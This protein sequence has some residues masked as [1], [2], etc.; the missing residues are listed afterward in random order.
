M[1]TPRILVFLAD[2]YEDLEVHYPRLRLLEAGFS[3]TL[4]GPAQG[5]VYRGKHGY[6][7]R[8]DA[9]LAGV[10]AE[11]FDGLVVPGGWMPDKLRRDPAVLAITHAIHAAGKLVASICH[12][13]WIDISARIVEGYRYT[14]TPGIKDDLQNA[15][16]LWSDAPMVRDRNRV[17]SR[18][19]DDLPAFLT[20]ILGWF[21][22]LKRR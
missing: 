15:G 4:A 20:G 2:D 6:P 21:E 9:A 18:R 10:D 12:G 1:S 16:A 22:E 5:T 7:A 13:P 14:S 11:R 3:V 17:S 8:S 19:P